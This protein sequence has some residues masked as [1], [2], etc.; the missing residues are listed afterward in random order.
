MT[1]NYDR[2]AA[3]MPSKRYRFPEGTMTI[4]DWVERY[5]VKL[6]TGKQPKLRYDR[7][8]YNRL[9]GEEA[10]QYDRDTSTPTVVYYEAWTDKETGQDIPKSIFDMYKGKIKVE[11]KDRTR[12]P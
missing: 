12:K 11:H 8:K 7:V 1:Y 6:V 4:G 3:S 10:E 5:A 9:S 2:T